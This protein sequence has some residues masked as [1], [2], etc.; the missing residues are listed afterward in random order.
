MIKIQ[1]PS[2]INTYLLCPRKYYY[3]Y[4]KRLIPPEDIALIR[5]RIL[6]KVVENIFNIK[7]LSENYEFE[8][9]I[10]S[11]DLLNK[12]WNENLPTIKSLNLNQNVINSYFEESKEMALKFINHITNKIKQS[13]LDV[14]TTFN[15]MK[16]IREITL[17]SGQLGVKGIIDVVND[18]K[19]IDYKTS[20]RDDITEEYKT[21]L[22]I[23]S[24]LFNEKFKKPLSSASL[25]FF[26]FGER[27]VKITDSDIIEAKEKINIVKSKTSSE[28]LIDYPQ[29]I[30]R[31]CKWSTG[32]CPYFGLCFP[33]DNPNS[34]NNSKLYK[35]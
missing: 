24:I 14:N 31:F 15:N 7:E 2:S 1:S 33:K 21:Q 26:K 22:G 30:G 20:S 8:L 25:F 17:E 23:Y 4:I 6:H 35:Y 16:G 9:K 11:L 5:G 19:I 28:N 34:K 32:K 27:E 10:V 12:V 18:D 13:S 29:K 3:R